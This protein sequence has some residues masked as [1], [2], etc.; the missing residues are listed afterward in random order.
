[1]IT[2]GGGFIGTQ[3]A[4]RLAEDNA[5]TLLD[6]DFDH[7]SFAFTE[8][9]ANKNIK[10]ATAD[11]L[12]SEK[13]AGIAR[14]AQIVIHTA[15]VLGVQKVTQNAIQTIEVNYLGIS[16]LLKILSQSSY[17]ERFV[18]FSTSEIYGSNAFQIAEDG[19]AVFPSIQN[20]RWCYSISKLA[21]EH[22]TFGYHRQKGLPAV[23]IRPFNLFG[24]GRIGSYAILQFILRALRNEDLEVYGDGTQIRAWCYI[25]D[26]C[27]ALLRSI[28]PKEAIGQ[29]FNIGNPLNTL[30]IYELARKIIRLCGAT[31]KIVFKP[32]D[33]EDIDIRVPDISRARDI[34]G[35]SPEIEIDEGLSRT[36]EWMKKNYDSLTF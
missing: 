2:G 36:I 13:L 24:P 15:A 28:E 18:L 34:L 21:A 10:M 35:F 20:P 5:V 12:D 17:C 19:D 29:A 31:S 27:D 1:M 26:F 7:N 14:D 16:N 22:L 30:T 9:S 8:L 6:L 11:I 23:I 3:L 25:D 33:F 4:G 32:L